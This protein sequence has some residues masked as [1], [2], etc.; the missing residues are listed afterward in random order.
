MSSNSCQ[1]GGG[2]GGQEQSQWGDLSRP[3]ADQRQAILER[4]YQ[5]NAIRRSLGLRLL[6]VPRLYF[7]KVA[8]LANLTRKERS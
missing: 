7:Q 3:S 4:L 8:A 5:R 6:D 1:F 2:S